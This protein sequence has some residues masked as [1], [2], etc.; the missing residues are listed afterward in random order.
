MVNKKLEGIKS[1][2]FAISGAPFQAQSSYQDLQFSSMGAFAAKRNFSR[3]T[4]I[5]ATEG[6]DGG[7]DGPRGGKEF[8]DFKAT[9]IDGSETTLKD[10]CGDKKATLVVNVASE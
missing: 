1:S 2:L 10:L 3:T 4:R 6:G 9:K 8:F 7:G 5:H